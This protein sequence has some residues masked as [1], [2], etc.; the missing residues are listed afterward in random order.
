[1]SNDCIILKKYQEVKT[2]ADRIRNMSDEELLDF[3]CSII[4]YED[5]SE[6]TIENGSALCSVTD[7][8]D[9]LKA[10]VN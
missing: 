9:W 7:V 3:L 6:M 10:E 2:N 4:T 1:M 5:D 8:E